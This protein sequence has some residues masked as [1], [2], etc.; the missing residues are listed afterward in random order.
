VNPDH[1]AKRELIGKLFNNWKNAVLLS[2]EDLV[3]LFEIAAIN[4]YGDICVRA[5]YQQFHQLRENKNELRE[6]VLII[7]EHVLKMSNEIHMKEM[8]KI[9]LVHMENEEKIKNIKEEIKKL[10][11]DEREKFFFDSAFLLHDNN[12]AGYD[13]LM[14]E[15]L[16]K[17][18][19]YF[20]CF[21]NE[22]IKTD[23]RLLVVIMLRKKMH[24]AIEITNTLCPFIGGINNITIL[25]S[26]QEIQNF[27]LFID[28]LHTKKKEFNLLK[29]VSSANEWSTKTVEYY[30]EKFNKMNNKKREEF[31]VL[32]FG[33]KLSGDEEYGKFQKSIFEEFLSTAGNES[34]IRLI[35]DTF[36][37]WQF[38][39]LFN[40]VRSILS[41]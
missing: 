24:R 19:S 31:R 12:S 7:T 40:L 37:L 11:L 10:E 30:C 21:R 23:I 29:Q 18:T 14:H 20:G 2:N 33:R 4:I 3:K 38:P 34:T 35:W 22:A 6:F 1:Q 36:E 27:Q 17:S 16:E 25:K 9:I 41:I 5:I 15:F 8:L 32:F 13:T 39:F 28:D 26:Y